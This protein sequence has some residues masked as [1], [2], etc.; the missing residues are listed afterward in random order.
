MDFRV[1]SARR[2]PE[3]NDP[4]VDALPTLNPRGRAQIFGDLLGCAPDHRV[5]NARPII[6]VPRTIRGMPRDAGYPSDGDDRNGAPAKPKTKYEAREDRRW[7]HAPT[8]PCACVRRLTRIDPSL[9]VKD[10][11]KRSK[12]RWVSPSTV[13]GRGRRVGGWVR[14]WLLPKRRLNQDV[15]PVTQA[16]GVVS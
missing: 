15:G 4:D 9:L 5:P 2:F 14:E 16:C 1:R 3:R 8:V 7:N 12:A 11:S 6:R 13:G 10:L